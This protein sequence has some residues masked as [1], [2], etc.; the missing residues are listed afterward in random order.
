[1]NY[2]R[3][4]YI[5]SILSIWTA[6]TFS[7]D[8]LQIDPAHSSVEFSIRHLVGRVKGRFTEFSGM[9][10][11]D[12]DKITN[13]SLMVTIKTASIDTE[14]PKRDNHLRTP[15]FFDIEKYQ[16]ITF[17][18]KEIREE[19]NRLVAVGLLKM[20]GIEKEVA[21]PFKVL[22]VMKDPKGGMRAGF[23]AGITLN[24]KDFDL[25]WNRVLDNGG[26]LLGEEVKVSLLVEAVMN[27]EEK[28]EKENEKK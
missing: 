4:F 16:E 3:L 19:E 13:S 6:N 5:G 21:L 20:H 1:M 7:A 9:I 12:E 22:G 18:S 2:R 27:N 8:S 14:I 10:V 11:Y 15:E 25:T 24:R 17:R 28:K 26:F 23:E